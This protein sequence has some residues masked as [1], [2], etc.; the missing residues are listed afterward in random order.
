MRVP[1][2]GDGSTRSCT[3]SEVISFYNPQSRFIS[4]LWFQTMI[5]FASA[6]SFRFCDRLPGI[7]ASHGTRL[8]PRCR[9]RPAVTQGRKTS[10][11]QRTQRR[12][13][14]RTFGEEN[15][16]CGPLF[17]EISRAAGPP[18]QTTKDDGLPHE[19]EWTGQEACPTVY[20]KMPR[21]RVASATRETAR[22]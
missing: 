21:T 18:K 7:R 8:S 19:R 6:L 4:G 14:K 16:Q 11:N 17:H 2:A 12:T 9:I 3:K 10:R 22:M 20:G 5:H 15:S 13:E 1:R